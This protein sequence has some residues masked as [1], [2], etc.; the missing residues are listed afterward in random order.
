M[1]D[2][3]K[4]GK[5]PGNNPA[6]SVAEAKARLSEVIERAQAGAPQLIT[7]NGRKTVFVVSAEDWEKARKPKQSFYEFLRASPLVGVEL[8]IERDKS[9]PRDIEL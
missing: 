3:R 8:D 1:D 6:W 5:K 2:I 4:L 9:G 7:K